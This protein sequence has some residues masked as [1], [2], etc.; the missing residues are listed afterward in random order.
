MMDLLHVCL[1]MFMVIC[2]LLTCLFLATPNLGYD[3]FTGVV[4]S[5]S[6]INTMTSPHFPFLMHILF[7]LLSLC[8]CM[9][10]DAIESE[11][12]KLNAMVLVLLCHL[13]FVGVVSF[14]ART[15]LGILNFFLNMLLIVSLVVCWSLLDWAVPLHQAGMIL[16]SVV[17][18]A[19]TLIVGG[20]VAAELDELSLSTLAHSLGY[21]WIVAWFFMFS[22]YVFV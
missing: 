8:L 18:V 3:V 15:N 13:A 9:R 19:V 2:A 7:G 20:A 16:F 10:V 12:G 17:S 22:V 14:D 11:D 4:R 6:E 1:V 21:V 5:F